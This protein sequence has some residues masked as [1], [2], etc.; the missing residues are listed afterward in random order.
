MIVLKIALRNLLEHRSKTAIVG[1]LIVLAVALMVTGTSI[2]DSIRR[3]LKQS[4]SQNYTGDL[5]VHGLSSESF[6]LV[7]M[8]GGNTEIPLLPS[9]PSLMEAVN[10]TSGVSQTLPL[11]SGA[12]SLIVNEEMASFTLLWGTDFSAYRRMFPDTVD[13]IEGAYPQD[14]GANLLLSQTVRESAEKELG[15]RIALGDTVTLGGFGAG[16][17]RLRTAKIAGFFKFKRG[18]AQLDRIS[19]VSAGTLRSLKGMT[20]KPAVPQNAAPGHSLSSGGAATEAPATGLGVSDAALFGDPNSLVQ[21]P[22]AVSQGAQRIN[23]DTILGDTSIRNAYSEVD[24]NAWNFL[25][26]K[27][28]PSASVLGVQKSLRAYLT[29]QG[30]DAAVSD[31][32][33]GAGP[34]AT[35]ALSLQ[36]IFN[37]IIFIILVV[38]VIII[39]NTLV[40]SVTERIGEIGTIRAIGGGKPFIRKMIVWETLTLSITAGLGGVVLGTLLIGIINGIGIQSSNV[41]FEILF[42]GTTLRPIVSFGSVFWSLVSTVG[43]GVLSSLYPTAVALRI[44]PVRAM[45]KN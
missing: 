34:V 5:I 9:F 37:I 7:A 30:L 43:I 45:Q 35:L 36:L 8:G 23:F 42:G 18:N 11:V 16:G 1:T 14:D 26:V 40:I 10:K 27:T 12:A 44:S 15:H 28:S 25:L 20:M 17:T 32:S 24:P 31:W 3:G 19:L 4:Y 22:L 6:S 33:W 2:M 41:F 21:S 13:I 38:A 39:M 29:Q